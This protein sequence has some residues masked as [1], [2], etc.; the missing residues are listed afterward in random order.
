MIRQAI[1]IISGMIINKNKI[2]IINQIK[3]INP[4]E[5]TKN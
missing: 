5:Q 1:F 3:Q 2:F 4:A